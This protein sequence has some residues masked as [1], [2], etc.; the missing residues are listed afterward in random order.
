MEALAHGLFEGQIAPT[1]NISW[2]YAF[3][4]SYIPGGMHPYHS[5]NGIW[6]FALIECLTIDDLPKSKSFWE[7]IQAY[8]HIRS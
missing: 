5:L 6:P 1:S 4:S 7:K 2:M 8:S 3:T